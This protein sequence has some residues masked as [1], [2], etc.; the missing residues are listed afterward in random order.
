VGLSDSEKK[1]AK[2][3]LMTQSCRSPVSFQVSDWD[4]ILFI[5]YFTKCFY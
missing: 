2:Q 4:K 5:H 3:Q 1:K